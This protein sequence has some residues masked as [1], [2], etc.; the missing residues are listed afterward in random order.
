MMGKSADSYPVAMLLLCL[1]PLVQACDKDAVCRRHPSR[2]ESSLMVCMTADERASCTGDSGA[3]I[4]FTA[5]DLN[6]RAKEVHHWTDI[7]ADDHNSTSILR[8][9]KSPHPFFPQK[10]SQISSM[11]MMI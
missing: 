10:I 8:F 6:Y 9:S 7:L 1:I 3:P 2:C 4:F 11:R 5:A